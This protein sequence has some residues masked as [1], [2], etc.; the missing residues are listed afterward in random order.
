[1]RAL[2]RAAWLHP[3]RIRA[4][5]R[6]LLAAEV[7]GLVFLILG[8]HGLIVP[9]EKPTTTDFVSFYAAGMLALQGTPA[10]A[11][12]QAVHFALEQQVTAPGIG[13]QYFF[14]PPVYLLLCAPLALLP[15][16]VSFVL[17]Q[18]L[19]LGFFLLVLHRIMG[20]AGPGWMVA[21][22]AFP[23]VFW[24]L[25][26]GQNSFL[27]AGLLG[28]GM[29]W[30]APRPL[31]AGLVLGAIC[32]KPHFGVLL[33][34]ALLLGR[35]WWAIAG[36]AVMVL[37]LIGLSILAF[38]MGSWQA[39]LGAMQGA[40]A[41]YETGTIDFIGMVTP[42]GGA[43]LMGFSP[44]TAHLIQA[45]ATAGAALVV[46]WVWYSPTSLAVR[47]ATL[48]AGSLL[49]VHL[50]LVY[51]MLLALLAIAWLVRAGAEN[52]ARGGEKLVFLAVYMAMLLLTKW[53]ILRGVGGAAA[54]PLG[55]VVC[56]ALLILCVLRARAEMRP[57]FPRDSGLGDS[58]AG[59]SGLG[60]SGLAGQARQLL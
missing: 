39:Y 57:D 19:G 9:V 42:F 30:L 36:A 40:R 28:L 32:Y 59:D 50:A 45:V 47:A 34:L 56:I 27:T 53:L 48:A 4:G 8:T 14:Y 31:L 24:V 21:A 16:L 54:I 49:A 6:V 41:V 23:P 55:P 17:F 60:D 18:V 29:L 13:Y 38:G 35:Q 46:G 1:M 43:L 20:A 26:L 22:L 58:G 52:G 2:L 12:D 15:Y 10:L 7:I 25:G 33:P 44:G 37:G 5:T 51:D 11:Y 3:A